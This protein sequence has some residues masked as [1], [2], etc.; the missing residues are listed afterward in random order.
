MAYL[1]NRHYLWLFFLLP[2]ILLLFTIAFYQQR[3]KSGEAQIQA[4]KSTALQADNS[5]SREIAALSTRVVEAEQEENRL[6]ASL[7]Q[8]NNELAQSQIEINALESENADLLAAAL[9]N[10]ANELAA[11]S[12]RWLSENPPLSTLLALEAYRLE[13]T[14]KARKAIFDNLQYYGGMGVYGHTGAIDVLEVSPNNKWLATAGR[15]PFILLYPL[16][17]IDQIQNP[18]VL[19]GPPNGIADVAFHPNGRW[20]ATAGRDGNIYLWDLKN[21][22]SAANPIVLEDRQYGILATAFSNDGRWL[23]TSGSGEE[24]NVWATDFLNVSEPDFSLLIPNSRNPIWTISPDSQWLF[25]FDKGEIV[26][27]NLTALD[28]PAS[29]YKITVPVDTTVKSGQLFGQEIVFSPNGRWLALTIYDGLVTNG[30]FMWDLTADENLETPLVLLSGTHGRS[31][32][33]TFSPDSTRLAVGVEPNGANRILI[34]DLEGLPDSAANPIEYRSHD[35]YLYD[36]VFSPNSSLLASGHR[37][38]L[39]RLWNAE[40]FEGRSLELTGFGDSVGYLTSSQDGQYL[41]AA[42]G[43]LFT[44]I[45]KDNGVRIWNWIEFPTFPALPISLGRYENWVTD[46]ILT[47]DEQWLIVFDHHICDGENCRPSGDAR[48]S[49]FAYDGE[50]FDPSQ[51]ILLED[52]GEIQLKAVSSNG[53]WLAMALDRSDLWVLDL[54]SADP[55]NSIRHFSIG[56]ERIRHLTFTKNNQR[57]IYVSEGGVFNLVLTTENS[58]PQPM[59]DTIW[60]DYIDWAIVNGDGN[61]L[62]VKN[63]VRSISQWNL[64]HNNQFKPNDIAVGNLF[65]THFKMVAVTSDNRWMAIAFNQPHNDLRLVDLQS[66]D[67]E[68]NSI[69]LTQFNIDRFNAVIDLL[70]LSFTSDGQYLLSGWAIGDNR[71]MRWNISAS[72]PENAPDLLTCGDDHLLGVSFDGNWAVTGGENQPTCL[73]NT[74][75]AVLS[76]IELQQIQEKPLNVSFSQDNQRLAIQS[77][78]QI[79]VFDLTVE[80]PNES[81][82]YFEFEGSAKT[83]GFTADGKWLIIDEIT[84][85]R[86]LLWP[87]NE[88]ILI[89]MACRQVGRNL[90]QTEWNDFFFQEPYQ[91]SC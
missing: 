26:R 24:V 4:I 27:W 13:G 56:S 55:A 88:D 58:K 84:G 51:T 76:P 67:P 23:I 60:D 19:P 48:V 15:D 64:D 32:G 22:N 91:K 47:P 78:G 81:G 46:F 61:T 28:I 74:A 42:A 62:Y 7:T 87:L 70:F 9:E 85:N 5:S 35:A 10:R 77:D 57:L 69:I 41:F 30:V 36:L 40:V 45:K 59:L 16:S 33:L 43:D 66:D 80:D 73:W 17:T 31:S 2:I 75:A 25:L 37:D 89:D 50:K 82:F 54:H 83:M 11:D 71:A 65:D 63:R 68:K 20:L 52:E 44:S 18:F 8:S 38:G 12:M 53:R 29:A 72:D 34:W 90:T 39:V 21:V 79:F 86:L 14:P 49:L 6:N 1:R 3:L